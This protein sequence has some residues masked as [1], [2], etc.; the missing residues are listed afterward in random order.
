MSWVSYFMAGLQPL[1]LYISTG[2]WVLHTANV[3]QNSH[4]QR[5]FCKK[6]EKTQKSNKFAAKFSKKPFFL[7]CT[8]MLVEGFI[9]KKQL[10]LFLEI[11]LFIRIF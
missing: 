9:P 1:M 11:N 2:V 7:V 4:F 6:A 5:F 8:K 10:F 3:G